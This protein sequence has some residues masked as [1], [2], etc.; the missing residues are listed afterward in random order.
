[1]SLGEHQRLL[2]TSVPNLLGFIHSSSI[3]AH[4]PTADWTSNA[5]L[6]RSK[7]TVCPSHLV[8]VMPEHCAITN[9]AFKSADHEASANLWPGLQRLRGMVCRLLMAHCLGMVWS[10]RGGSML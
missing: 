5:V 9:L 1:M 6:C 7:I 2:L 3:A 8:P 4:L 10:D